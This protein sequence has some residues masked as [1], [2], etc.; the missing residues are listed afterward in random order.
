MTLASVHN[1]LTVVGVAMEAL[2]LVGSFGCDHPLSKL[3]SVLV[4]TNIAVLFKTA[5][6]STPQS[7]NMSSGLTYE[8]ETFPSIIFVI[9]LEIS[10]R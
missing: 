2:N 3:P 10:I 8:A 6:R 1:P 4:S 9:R 7:G 5:T